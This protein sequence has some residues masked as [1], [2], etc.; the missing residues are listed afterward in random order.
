MHCHY[1][2]TWHL[3]PQTFGKAVS[4]LIRMDL[5]S[6][7]EERVVTEAWEV[8]LTSLDGSVSVGC[9]LHNYG[10]SASGHS[11]HATFYGNSFTDFS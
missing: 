4:G 6:G 11:L 1:T 8:V 7:S 3:L 2:K 10:D 9:Q 5:A